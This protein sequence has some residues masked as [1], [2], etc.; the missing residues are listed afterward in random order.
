MVTL[1][2]NSTVVVDTL[3][4]RDHHQRRCV[5]MAEKKVKQGHTHT[6]TH[7]GKR[8]YLKTEKISHTSGTTDLNKTWGS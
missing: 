2:W 6:H 5:C 7:P 4:A 3:K 8:R 1:E